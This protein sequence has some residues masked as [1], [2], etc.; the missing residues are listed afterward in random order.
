[1]YRQAQALGLD[2]QTFVVQSLRATIAAMERR[3]QVQTQIKAPES[4]GPGRPAPAVPKSKKSLY[5]DEQVWAALED[6]GRQNG[7]IGVSAAANQLLRGAL[8]LDGKR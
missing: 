5:L 7:D 4:R 3:E 6:Y 2:V 8:G 1:V